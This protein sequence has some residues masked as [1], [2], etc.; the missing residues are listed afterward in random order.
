MLPV[1][2]CMFSNWQKCLRKPRWCNINDKVVWWRGIS[3]LKTKCIPN[4]HYC[5]WL[6]LFKAT[7]HELRKY[8]GKIIPLHRVVRLTYLI[9]H[10][11]QPK[12]GSLQDNNRK[13]LKQTNSKFAWEWIFTSQGLITNNLYFWTS[14]Q[15]DFFESQESVGTHTLILAICTRSLYCM[16]IFIH[17]WQKWHSC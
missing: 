16:F 14:F 10:T 3:T 11:V 9:F 6:V 2:L 4:R 15:A 17:P 8:L 5:T 13:G 12:M 7:I 1:E